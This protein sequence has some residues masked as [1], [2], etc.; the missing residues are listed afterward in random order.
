M[1]E[2]A[3]KDKIRTKGGGGEEV[4]GG[5][6]PSMKSS[7]AI[8][9]VPSENTSLTK[10]VLTNESSLPSSSS[11]SSSSA[12]IGSS[13]PSLTKVNSSRITLVPLSSSATSNVNSETVKLTTKTPIKF[14]TE[15][16]SQNSLSF[17]PTQNSS[18]T[19]AKKL[20]H[21]T[22]N[23]SGN[24][25]SGGSSSQATL[26]TSSTVRGLCATGP[27]S[28][29]A[30]KIL[31]LSSNN[32]SSNVNSGHSGLVGLT[33]NENKIH[34]VKILNTPAS[35]NLVAVSGSSLSSSVTT[36]QSQMNISNAPNSIKITTISSNTSSSS[37]AAAA[38]VQVS[39]CFSLK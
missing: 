23:G 6:P 31:S 15:I 8:I 20:I 38:N 33:S 35:A 26:L 29:Q 11:S 39:F 2:T 17:T 4:S 25:T 14:V 36:P 12:A 10:V 30:P 21:L 13:Q 24:L 34:Y 16:N 18:P 5:E 7:Q 22:S 27:N 28:T 3:E 9:V 37:A 32:S 19:T 1:S